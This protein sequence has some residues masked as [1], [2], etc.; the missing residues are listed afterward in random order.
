MKAPLN[1]NLAC[2][3]C[4][5]YS[6]EG[7][8]GGT[9]DRLSVHVQGEWAACSLMIPSFSLEQEQVEQPSLLVAA[10]Q[11]LTQLSSQSQPILVTEAASTLH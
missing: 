7:H 9:C 4:R 6:P 5:Y 1:P 8:R 3:Y 10:N 2:R 11:T